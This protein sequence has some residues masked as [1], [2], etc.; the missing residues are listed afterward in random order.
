MDKRTEI[1]Y[2]LTWKSDTQRTPKVAHFPSSGRSYAEECYEEKLAEGKNPQ[3]W[4]VET[5]T[6]FE[7]M[8]PQEDNND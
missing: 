8:Y 2:R 4:K 5:I 3:L 7:N 1:M 6:T